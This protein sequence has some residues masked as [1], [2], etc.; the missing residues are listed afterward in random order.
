MNNPFAVILVAADFAIMSGGEPD[1][2][3]IQAE[4][5]KKLRGQAIR[6]GKN[7]RSLL[8]LSKSSSTQRESHEL[9]ACVESAI[10]SVTDG[11]ASTDGEVQ[12][13]VRPGATG[14]HVLVN[15]TELEE[16]FVNL[17]R[18]GLESKPSDARVM[19]DIVPGEPEG[20]RIFVR[21]NGPGVDPA[22]MD[23]LSESSFTDR[24]RKAGTGLGLSVAH[25]IIAD[26][27]GRIGYQSS[28]ERPPAAEDSEFGGAEFYVR[29]PLE[30]TD[31]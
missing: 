16:V 29:L 1:G 22:D 17:I 3:E 15:A 14:L 2:L 5:L 8:K 10:A 27:G 28:D 24:L 13:R 19:V 23:R 12:L 25:R 31:E 20:V 30:K 21:D 26:F 9:V 11:L 6:C 4:A 7:V 18:N